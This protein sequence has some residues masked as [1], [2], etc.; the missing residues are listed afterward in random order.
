MI[1]LN[2]QIATW[3]EFLRSFTVLF[4]VLQTGL[5]YETLLAGDLFAIHAL[6]NIVYIIISKA[7]SIRLATI[8][9]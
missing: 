2:S 5:V 4:L 3:L 9:T 8:K 7:T 1:L 6:I